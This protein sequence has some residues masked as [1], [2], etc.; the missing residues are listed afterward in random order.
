MKIEI[1]ATA[2]LV[3][4]TLVCWFTI[5]YYNSL[6]NKKWLLSILAIPFGWLGLVILISW[7]IEKIYL[8][9]LKIR[10]NE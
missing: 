3:L 5:W 4:G 9:I 1:I 10:G 6:S 7:I 2:L 8:L